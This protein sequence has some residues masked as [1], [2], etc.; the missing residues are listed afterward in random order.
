MA[1][2]SLVR[3]TLHVCGVA[4]QPGDMPRGNMKSSVAM[5]SQPHLLLVEELLIRTA[6][7][8]ELPPSLH[9]LAVDRYE[10]IRKHIERDGSPL[11]DRVRLF[12]PQGS[13]AIGATIRS[14]KRAD[15]YDID[16]VAELLLPSGTPPALVLDLLFE[17]INGQRGSR[18]HGKVKRQTRCITVEYEDGMHLDVTPSILII[19]NDP[20]VSKIFHAKPEEP[21][22]QHRRLVINSFAFVEHVKACTPNDLDFRHRYARE[23]KRFADGFPLQIKADAD[24]VDVPAHST[25]DGGKSVTIV[26]LQL[27][28]R[29]RNEK[30]TRRRGVRMPPSVMLSKF[31]ADVARPGAMLIEALVALTEHILAQ[32]EH[33]HSAGI[34]IDVRNPKCSQDRFTDRWPENAAAQNLYISDLRVFR[35][36][37]ELLVGGTLSLAQMRDLLVEMFGEGP[38]QGAIDDFAT[39]QGAAV[40]DNRPR[41]SVGAGA[42]RTVAAIAAPTAVS[43]ATRAT[44]HTFYGTPWPKQKKR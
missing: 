38:A 34:L 13:M 9:N 27:K 4:C 17:A 8:V 22:H 11:K 30:Y 21:V 2:V 43:S 3:Q 29:N 26:A 39:G 5:R 1:Y 35:N 41:F 23:V 20:R 12:Y 33:A 10:A 44:A 37:L 19:A 15:G 31:A 18:Y 6:V 32:L 28:K 36:Q 42:T 16:I 40:R 24:V 14:R 7:R 25:E